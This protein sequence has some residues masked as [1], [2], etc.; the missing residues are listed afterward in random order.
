[1]NKITN[2]IKNH[3][4]AAGALSAIGAG[5]YAVYQLSHGDP[6]PAIGL[7]EAY[8][9]NNLLQM[10]CEKLGNKLTDYDPK[11]FNWGWFFWD[12]MQNN[13]SEGVY[14]NLIVDVMDY[15]NCPVPGT[16]ETSDVFK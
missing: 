10:S 11:F 4:K 1:M 8:A 12:S 14:K 2:F 15:K 16:P 7:E 9:S 3:K 6:V 13:I 5:A